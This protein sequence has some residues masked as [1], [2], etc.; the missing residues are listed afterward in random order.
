MLAMDETREKTLRFLEKAR[1][2]GKTIFF[3]PGPLALD[4]LAVEKTFSLSDVLILNDTEAAFWSG[5]KTVEESA[6][7]LGAR[8]RG[9]AVVKSGERGCS[10]FSAGGSGGRW[11]EG[12]EVKALDTTGAGDAFIA[13]FMR[14]CLDGWDAE[15]SAALANAAGAATAAKQGTGHAVATA[16]EVAAVLS[17]AGY[18]LAPGALAKRGA[19]RLIKE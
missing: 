7:E 6:K 13:A 14:G 5:K 11:Y 18:A 17:K 8:I 15:S 10:I 9:M 12:F 2:L 1:G 19:L 3:D 16:D 4:R